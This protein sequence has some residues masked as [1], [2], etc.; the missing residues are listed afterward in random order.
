MKFSILLLLCFGLTACSVFQ[1]SDRSGYGFV[2]ESEISRS[3]PRNYFQAQKANELNQAM[4]ELGYN[5]NKV[6]TEQDAARLKLRLMLRD[7]ENQLTTRKEKQQYFK[8]KPYFKNDLE[9][10]RYLKLPSDNHRRQWIQAKGISSENEEYDEPTL[11]AIE[12]NDV[13]LGMTMNAV[14]ESWGDPDFV[15]VAGDKLYGN[16]RWGYSKYV[17]SESGYNKEQR[18]IIFEAGRVAGWDRRERF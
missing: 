17:S 7:Y 15:E 8:L 16:E 9:R 3:T 10:I 2:G 11:A 1:R 13:V 6:I 5:K 4:N 12:S 14:K 18:I